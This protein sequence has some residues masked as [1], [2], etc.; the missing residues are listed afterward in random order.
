MPSLDDN[1]VWIEVQRQI[2]FFL[3]KFGYVNSAINL[4][5]I[6]NIAMDLLGEELFV[7]YYDEPEIVKHV[8]DI[9]TKLSIEVGKRLQAVSS[10]IS[11]GVTGILK[12][13]A[14]S[15]YLTSNCSVE[16]LS[17]DIYEEFLLECDRKLAKAFQPF[18]IHH[19]G[20]TAEHI[21]EGYKK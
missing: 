9:I 17:L 6:Q 10:S 3:S 8:L 7:G 13:V 1:P 16:M 4:M 5:G 11:N 12:E 19:C 14:P 2:D 21:S 18:G 20:Q 15:V